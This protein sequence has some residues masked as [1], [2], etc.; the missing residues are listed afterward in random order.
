MKS[1]INLCLLLIITILFILLYMLLGF[2][3]RMPYEDYCFLSQ[4][5]NAG[6]I[7]VMLKTYNEYCARWSAYSIAFMFAPLYS[8]GFF[9]PVF[10]ACALVILFCSFFFLIKR[11][12]TLLFRKGI[13]NVMLMTYTLI[14]T[15]CFFF[16]SY[17]IGE[18]WFWY[19]SD[20]AYLCSIIAGNF[21][22]WILFSGKLKV[23]YVSLIVRSEEQRV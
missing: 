5:K 22:F 8:T 10:H 23:V 2:H 1:G 20:W 19:M 12:V 15:L 14:F 13:S 21:L 7:E 18:V 16:S 4:L 3:N 11:I 6:A 9:L 17:N